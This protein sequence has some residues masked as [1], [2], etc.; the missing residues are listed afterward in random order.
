MECVSIECFSTPFF[1]NHSGRGV[2]LFNVGWRNSSTRAST[3]SFNVASTFWRSLTLQ[4]WTFIFGRKKS[5]PGIVV[6]PISRRGAKFG[7]IFDFRLR[8]TGTDG[9][10]QSIIKVESNH[11][12][13]TR[14]WQQGFVVGLSRIEAI[15]QISHTFDSVLSIQQWFWILGKIFWIFKIETGWKRNKKIYGFSCAVKITKTFKDPVDCNWVI[16]QII[17]I[18]RNV[19]SISETRNKCL[20]NQ[21]WKFL[22]FLKII[23]FTWGKFL[24][25]DHWV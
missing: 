23:I 6:L 16:A 5:F 4:K 10:I 20:R 15:R 21:P 24:V 2:R 1:K 13:R 22:F 8:P 19:M 17:W 18:Q 9:C 7:V 12:R 11:L 14:C 3:I 25:V